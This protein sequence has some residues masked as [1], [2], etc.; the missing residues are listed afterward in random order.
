MWYNFFVINVFGVWKCSVV[1]FFI[2]SKALFSA[3]YPSLC[4]FKLQKLSLVHVRVNDSFVISGRNL[5][6]FDV[7][8]V[9]IDEYYAVHYAFDCISNVWNT[10]VVNYNANGEAK[11]KVFNC[12][13]NFK[14]GNEEFIVN[15]IIERH[16][17]RHDF[18]AFDK[19]N[20]VQNI[21]KNKGTV[22]FNFQNQIPRF[23][24]HFCRSRNQSCWCPNR[25]WELD[26]Q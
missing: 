12:F 17:F 21:K 25:A 14:E 13:A 16:D 22:S 11:T 20:G 10:D 2:V 18:Y 19:S 26:L 1:L 3:S 15:N 24:G 7:W 5:I 23:W 8:I 6:R 4:I 9:L